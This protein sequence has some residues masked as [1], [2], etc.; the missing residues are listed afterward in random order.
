MILIAEDEIRNKLKQKYNNDVDIDNCHNQVIFE[1]NFFDE[2]KYDILNIMYGVIKLSDEQE[3]CIKEY[4]PQIKKLSENYCVTNTYTIYDDYEIY[5]TNGDY[6]GDIVFCHPEHD[7]PMSTVDDLC[8]FLDDMK[9]NSLYDR[10]NEYISLNDIEP[11]DDIAIELEENDFSM[12]YVEVESRPSERNI[13]TFLTKE[14]CENHIKS[15]RH[16]YT[17][18]KVVCTNIFRNHLLDSVIDVFTSIGDKL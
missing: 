2:H 7:Y 3:S 11:Y 10:L 1:P 14:T 18:P 16:H 4:A 17:N 13:Q 6:G 15:N 8:E 5:R 9:L 12:Y